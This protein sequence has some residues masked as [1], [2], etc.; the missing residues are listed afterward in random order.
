MKSPLVAA[1]FRDTGSQA[2]YPTLHWKKGRT[3][4]SQPFQSPVCYTRNAVPSVSAS[5]VVTPSNANDV[6]K[7]K[8]VAG[9]YTFGPQSVTPGGGAYKGRFF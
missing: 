9:P 3:E 5:F 1:I 7:V 8:G 6:V 4:G 2:A